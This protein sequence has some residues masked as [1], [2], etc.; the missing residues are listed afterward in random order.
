M[1]QFLPFENQVHN[2]Y[3]FCSLTVDF[4]IEIIAHEAKILT[5]DNR[6]PFLLHFNL[7]TNCVARS[8]DSQIIFSWSLFQ[9]YYEA[10]LDRSKKDSQHDETYYSAISVTTTYNLARL[11]EALHEYDKADKFYR[12]ILR[13]HPNYVDCE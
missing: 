3:T 10:S 4:S 6:T 13:D 12:N 8:N 5:F 1:I 9:K 11:Y 2:L 7:Y